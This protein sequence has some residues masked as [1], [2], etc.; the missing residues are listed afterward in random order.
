MNAN[1]RISA[2]KFKS[3]VD[4]N[5]EIN[6]SAKTGR[7]VIRSDGIDGRIAREGRRRVLWILSH[8]IK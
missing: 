7:R 3:E 6:V 1:L 8:N 2:A 4:D 5:L